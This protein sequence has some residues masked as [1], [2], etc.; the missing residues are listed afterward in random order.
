MDFSELLKILLGILFAIIGWFFI[1]YLNRQESDF[2][3]LNKKQEKV[4]E[5]LIETQQKNIESSNRLSNSID[6][7]NI[8]VTNIEAEAA[9]R[10]V[11]LNSRMDDL[12]AASEL[13]RLRVHFVINKLTV[14]KL[15]LEKLDGKTM[16][17]NWDSP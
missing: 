8:I 10:Y 7:L 12:H 1:K 17:G 11:A 9:Q 2:L 14:L 5:I 3:A 13:L 15:I 6:R 4:Y 16:S